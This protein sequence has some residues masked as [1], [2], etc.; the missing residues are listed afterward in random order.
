M[1]R[2]TAPADAAASQQP[3]TIAGMGSDRSLPG[4]DSPAVE[5]DFAKA[6]RRPGFAAAHQGKLAAM[7]GG[8]LAAAIAEYERIEESLG[9]LMSYAQ[10]LFAGDSTDAEIGRFYQTISERVTAISSHLL[11]FTLE[12]NRLDEAALEQKLRRS[13]AGA[14]AAL[15]ARPAR[16]R[17]HQLSDELEKMLHEKDVT[18]RSAWVRLFDETIA[19]HAVPLDGEELTVS[20]ALNKL[21]DRDRSVREAAGR[22]IGEAF[23]EISGCSRWSP[24]RWPRTRRSTTRGGTIRARQRPQPRQHGRG[25]GRRCAGH[26]GAGVFPAARASLLPDEGE[27]ARPAEAAALG[28]QRAAAG[29]R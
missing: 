18:G 20:A 27:L 13:G 23:G 24:T 21:S 6:E 25:R 26:G 22:A 15:A 19:A 2:Q 5:A 8:A 16:F 12:L 7:S 14:L 4:P 3:R 29:R 1:M 9:R 17:P 10:L 28:P 11:F